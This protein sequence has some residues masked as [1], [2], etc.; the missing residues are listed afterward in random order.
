MVDVAAQKI[1][2][3]AAAGESHGLD[4]QRSARAL[5]TMN[6]HYFLEELVGDPNA[7]VDAAV[8]TLTRI[9]ERAIYLEDFPG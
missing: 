9:W 1:V 7:D 4:P 8:T 6:V 2:E 5:V 3:A